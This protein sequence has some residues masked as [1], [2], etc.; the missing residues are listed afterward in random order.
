MLFIKTVEY[1]LF[2]LS[3]SCEL[4]VTRFL[5]A[6]K[7]AECLKIHSGRTFQSRPAISR[8]RN[9]NIMTLTRHVV[10]GTT[11]TKTPDRPEVFASFP[12]RN[13]R[14]DGMPIC[15]NRMDWF[16]AK[17]TTRRI[18]F[19]RENKNKTVWR[20]ATGGGGGGVD[21]ISE[22]PRVCESTLLSGWTVRGPVTWNR[23]RFGFRAVV[24]GCFVLIP[25][26]FWRRVK[27]ISF[28]PTQTHTFWIS[29]RTAAAAAF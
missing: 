27:S 4:R 18:G 24:G 3:Y 28:L 2:R 14:S 5:P 19:N 16:S 15:G 17:S 1:T 8:H 6:N 21:F 26:G 20:R 12:F 10:S 22:Y 9:D 29:N 11:K 23:T 7:H 13:T 25:T